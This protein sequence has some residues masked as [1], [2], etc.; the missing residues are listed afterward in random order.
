MIYA[1]Y[2]RIDYEG[3]DSMILG[4]SIEALKDYYS[5]DPDGNWMR[6]SFDAFEWDDW[7]NEQYKGSNKHGRGESLII[8]PFDVVGEN[9]LKAKLEKQLKEAQ[10]DLTNYEETED[11]SEWQL[12]NE[13]ILVLEYV[14]EMLSEQS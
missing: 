10:D 11:L 7:E 2:W 5:N 12:I 13:R 14:L 4:Y 1:M 8:E 3:S 9:P 6:R